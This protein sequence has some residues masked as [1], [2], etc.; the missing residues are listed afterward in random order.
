LSIDALL[1]SGLP[2]GTSI[3]C[4][5]TGTSTGRQARLG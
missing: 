5:D 3:T 4:T 1:E 2:T